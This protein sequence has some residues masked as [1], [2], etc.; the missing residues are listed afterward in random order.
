MNHVCECC[1]ESEAVIR[2]SATDLD[3]NV[4][5]TELRCLEC[6]REWSPAYGIALDWRDN[7]E[8]K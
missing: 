6:A 7:Q 4:L 5:D 8:K 3:G 2:L 1:E